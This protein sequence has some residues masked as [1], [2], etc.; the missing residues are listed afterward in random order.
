MTDADIRGQV[1]Q[2][3]YLHRDEELTFAG[4]NDAFPIPNGIEPRAW[5]RACEQLAEKALIHWH[6]VYHNSDGRQ[7]LWVVDARINAAGIDIVEGTSTPPIAVHLDQ[8]QNISIHGSQGVQIAGANS[9]LQQ[10]ISDV[11]QN[12]IHDIDASSAS[13]EDKQ[14]AK[15]RLKTF[16][17]SKA[18]VAMLGPLA[19]ALIKRLFS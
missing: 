4:G 13:L 5:L 17:E 3:L 6:P 2:L 1:L 18:I 12:L 9:Q 14:E 11:L 16:L 10:M 19:E 7:H 8:S 15:G